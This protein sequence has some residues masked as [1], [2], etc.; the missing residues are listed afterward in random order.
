M[1]FHGNTVTVVNVKHH[2]HTSPT[3]GAFVVQQIGKEGARHTLQLGRT[4]NDYVFDLADG[5]LYIKRIDEEATG[6]VLNTGIRNLSCEYFLGDRDE[7][8]Y[9]G[10]STDTIPMGTFKEI[11]AGP[12]VTWKVTAYRGQRDPRH[13]KMEK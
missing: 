7:P 9:V 1:R 11:G 13:A 6:F 3:K 4:I 5:D 10:P 2:Y 8:T 12:G